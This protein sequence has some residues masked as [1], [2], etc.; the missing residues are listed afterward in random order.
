V[1]LCIVLGGQPQIDAALHLAGREPVWCGGY[2]I[3]D[4]AAMEAAIEVAG[5]GRTLAEQCLSKVGVCA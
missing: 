5:K 3:T 2:R 1:R 4:E